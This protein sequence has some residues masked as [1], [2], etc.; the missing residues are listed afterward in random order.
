[1]TC[2]SL[3]DRQPLSPFCRSKC[4]RE[5]TAIYVFPDRHTCVI[6]PAG[7]GLYRTRHVVRSEL[8]G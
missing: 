6:D 1:M 4:N 8:E 5:L 7:K 3:L 2:L